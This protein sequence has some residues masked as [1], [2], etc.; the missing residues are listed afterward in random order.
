MINIIIRIIRGGLAAAMTYIFL[1]LIDI[2][3][4]MTIVYDGYSYIFLNLNRYQVYDQHY[5]KNYSRWISGG[6]DVYIS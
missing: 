2:A 6:Y 5:Y 4:A 1:N 3:A